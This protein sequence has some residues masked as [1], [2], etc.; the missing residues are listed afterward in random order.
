MEDIRLE[1]LASRDILEN[2]SR[3]FELAASHIELIEKNIELINVAVEASKSNPI[4]KEDFIFVMQACVY[5]SANIL[6]D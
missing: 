2:K 6:F 4:T 3:H 1:L 5:I